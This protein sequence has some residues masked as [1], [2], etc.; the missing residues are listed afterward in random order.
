MERVNGTLQQSVKC[1]TLNVHYGRN[2]LDAIIKIAYCKE[3]ST[4]SMLCNRQ[5]LR[6]LGAADS[7]GLITQFRQ[8]RVTTREIKEFSKLLQA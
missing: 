3:G 7:L 4:V 8:S 1:Q 6:R 2:I 5:P